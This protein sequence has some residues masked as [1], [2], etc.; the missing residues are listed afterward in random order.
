MDE[1]TD[2]LVQLYD[3]RLH[4]HLLRPLLQIQ[5]CLSQQDQRSEFRQTQMHGPCDDERLGIRG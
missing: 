2:A 1:L 5:V 4:Q 3:I